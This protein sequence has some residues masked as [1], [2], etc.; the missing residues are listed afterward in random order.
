ME[1]VLH[2][3]Y[4]EIMCTLKESGMSYADLYVWRQHVTYKYIELVIR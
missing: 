1:N 2:S 3:I 4:W